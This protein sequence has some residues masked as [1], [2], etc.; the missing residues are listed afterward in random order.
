MFGE[1]FETR[2]H[3]DGRTDDTAIGLEQYQT[4]S[5]IRA[6]KARHNRA[7]RKSKLSIKNA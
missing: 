5:N 4:P 1:G 3:V 7:A 6:F 2:S